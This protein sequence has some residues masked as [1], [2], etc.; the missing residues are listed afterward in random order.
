MLKIFLK[1][2]DFREGSPL[3][4]TVIKKAI[5]N[6]RQWKD[7]CGEVRAAGRH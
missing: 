1:A 7:S 5:K 4:T 6:G 3:L 2:E